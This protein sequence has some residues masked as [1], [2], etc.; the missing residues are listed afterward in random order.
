VV[1]LTVA[2]AV[3]GTL[4]FVT[5]LPTPAS[6]TKADPRLTVAVDTVCTAQ[7]QRAVYATVAVLTKARSVVAESVSRTIHRAQ[8]V[9]A[10]WA[11]KAMVA[12]THAVDTGP[13]ACT[14]PGTH[15]L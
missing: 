4:W 12:V 10:V 2:R 15:A 13:V 8:P 11:R 6:G 1:A 7:V 5:P 14:V 9:G 3:V